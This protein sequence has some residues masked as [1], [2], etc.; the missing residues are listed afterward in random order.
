M[1]T[2]RT[3]F[4]KMVAVLMLAVC[5][6]ALAIPITESAS[7]TVGTGIRDNDLNGVADTRTL[8]SAINDITSLTVTL[9]IAGGYNGDLYAYLTHDS[10]FAV[11]LNRV[12]RTSTSAYGYADSGF[13]VT[14]ND[15]AANGD[16]HSYQ[17]TLN[18][19]GGALTGV[20][21]PDGRNIHPYQSLDSTAS[22]ALLSSFN[23]LDANGDWTLFVADAS[24]VGIARFEGWGLQIT[25]NA[26][27]VPDTGSTLGL[28]AMAMALALGASFRWPRR[29]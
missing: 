7:F 17:Q 1:K 3:Y 28:L 12:G 10:G 16:I 27:A 8:T 19:L 4:G 26:A 9:N 24:A 2:T 15:L 22:T 29:L 20:W 14:F 18:P 5:G 21:R 13:N 23:G 11:L 6:P 25:G